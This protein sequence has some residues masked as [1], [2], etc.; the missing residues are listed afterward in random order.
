LQWQHT[1]PV[2]TIFKSRYHGGWEYGKVEVYPSEQG[3][4]PPE[5]DLFLMLDESELTPEQIK[6]AIRTVWKDKGTRLQAA[7]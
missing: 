2:G 5:P 3:E 1:L 4:T 7:R 6:H